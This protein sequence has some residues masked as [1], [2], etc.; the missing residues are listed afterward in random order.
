MADEQF[1][2]LVRE[3]RIIQIG[4]AVMIVMMMAIEMPLAPRLTILRIIYCRT[5]SR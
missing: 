2:S 3:L 1:K 4:I 5:T